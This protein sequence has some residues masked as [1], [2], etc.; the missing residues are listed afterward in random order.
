MVA[1]AGPAGLTVETAQGNINIP[2]DGT[3]I[4]EQDRPG[5]V[6]VA[7]LLGGET[8]ISM[9]VNGEKKEL[10]AAA[11]E[12][13]IV[14]DA[15][16]S[17]EELIPVD[18][19]DREPLDAGK[20]VG[21]QVKKSKFERKQMIG[22]DMLVNCNMGCFSI[23]MRRSLDKLKQ[24]VNAD[25]VPPK[26]SRTPKNGAPVKVG[27][28]APVAPVGGKIST[29]PT[30]PAEN[31]VIIPIA[32]TTGSAGAIGSVMRSLATDTAMIKETRGTKLVMEKPGVVNL[33]GGEALVAASRA[34]LVRSGA[35]LVSVSAGTIALVSNENNVVKVRCLY[36]NSAHSVKL[37]AGNKLMTLS[38][39]QEFI[40][41]APDESIDNALKS[42]GLGRRKIQRF[43]LNKD[44]SLFHTEFSL[45]GL[46]QNNTILAELL[47][48]ADQDDHAMAEKL[49]KM[50]AVLTQVTARHG[51]YSA[52]GQ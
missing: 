45:V 33:K 49:V 6:R 1:S 27:S 26:V 20:I 18:G 50:A 35:S 12:E 31:S 28:G 24:D 29:V 42:D 23:T 43:D 40:V 51:A 37:Y 3:T 9:T 44:L 22:R 52:T 34:T 11:G 15:D 10:R 4:I 47:K 16:L 46:M 41:G 19:V 32:Y 21:L 8:K 25:S 39:G 5:V 36:D 13:L 30:S 7:N 14:A 38:S 48:A 2:S 17:E